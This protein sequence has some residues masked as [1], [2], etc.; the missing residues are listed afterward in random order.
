MPTPPLVAC[1]LPS[2][3]RWFAYDLCLGG[4]EAADHPGPLQTTQYQLQTTKGQW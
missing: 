2:Q 1:K 3:L 4:V